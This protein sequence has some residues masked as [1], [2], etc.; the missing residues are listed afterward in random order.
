VPHTSALLRA[1]IPLGAIL[2]SLSAF[3]LAV[4]A[5]L[6]ATQ[7]CSADE[8]ANYPAR[9]VR[10]IVP[11]GAGGTTD[12]VARTVAHALS[13]SLGATFLVEQKVGGNTNIGSAYVSKAVPDGY[14]LLVNTDT[15]TSNMTMYKDPGY[16]VIHGFAPVTMLTKAAGALV[17][18]KDL[19]VS[20][21]EE[22]VT[23]AR[24]K[25]KA[26]SVASTGTGTVSHLTGVMFRQRMDL[27]E[28]TDVPYQ[29]T[30][31]AMTDLLGGHVDAIVAMI[32][33]FVSQ[34]ASGDIKILAVT[35]KDRSPVAPGIPTIAEA[36]AL[37][38][39]D[40]SNWT[41][42]FAPPGTPGPVVEKLAS[43]VARVLKDPATV[44]KLAA[45]GLEPACDGP[46]ALARAVQG[47]VTQWRDVVLRAKLQTN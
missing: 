39:F 46:D 21:L 42:L 3:A 25:G 47:N 36:T 27:P 7:I 40:V 31:K 22:F 6:V 34:A 1:P 23:L 29:G 24:Q 38:D 2:R 4:S 43:E 13:Q 12:I 11:S 15:L 37:K 26:L 35:T 9:P 30:A 16:D 20:T 5:Y 32:P 28:W 33:N 8:A 10:F 19:G 14:T 17:V 18:R 45:V 44:Q 41:G